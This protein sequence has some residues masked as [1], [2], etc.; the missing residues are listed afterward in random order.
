MADPDAIAK[1]FVGHY[2]SMFDT[3]RAALA[4]MFQPTSMMSFEGDKFQGPDQIVGK[5]MKLQFQQCL[6]TTTLI[7][8]QPT[9]NN[10]VLVFC[11]GH[12]QTEGQE[13]PLMFSEVFTLMPTPEG[14]F[15]VYNNIFRLNLG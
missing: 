13:R 1:A 5:L 11:T 3:N 12:I 14:S 6:H 10:G 4:G 2:Y 9:V 8:A 15:Y 7:D